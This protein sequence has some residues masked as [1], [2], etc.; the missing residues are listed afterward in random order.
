[1]TARAWTRPS[2]SNASLLALRN[3][4][5]REGCARQP[6]T[7][8]ARPSPGLLPQAERTPPCLRVPPYE[9]VAPLH[10]AAGRDHPA[11]GRDP[12]GRHRRLSLPADLRPAGGRLPD[13]PGADLLSRRQSGGDDLVGHLAAGGAVRPDA[14]PEPDVLDQFGRGVGD[15]PAVQPGPQPGYR[16]AGGAGGDQRGGQPA[17]VRPAG[18]ADLRQGQ[19]RRRADPDPGA[20]LGHPAA[21]PGRGHG[22]TRGWRRRSRSSP[23]SGWSASAAARCRRCG[24]RSIRAPWRRTG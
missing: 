8:A 18:A 15:H 20:D 24:C 1:M 4:S 16:R 7:A 6:R 12:A 9:P 10:P 17:A 23:A 14:R 21:D 19:P 11:D 5:R 22:Q 2:R 3:G 13:H